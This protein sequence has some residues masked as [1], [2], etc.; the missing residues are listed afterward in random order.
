MPA[1]ALARAPE[2]AFPAKGPLIGLALLQS[3]LFLVPIVVLGQAI[4]WP[5]SLRLPAG[6]VLP[7]IAREAMA[8]QIGYWA[9]L[10]TSL[11]FVPLAVAMRSYANAKGIAGLTVDT[12]AALGVAAGILKTLGIVRW[13]VA[14][15]A[16]ADLY[17]STSDPVQKAAIEVAYSALNG[18][19]GAIGELLGV[20]L[21]SGIWLVLTGII[22]AKIRL[23]WIGTAAMVIGL[24]FTATCARTVMPEA[25]ALQSVAV[26]LALLWFPALAIAI[27][28]R[29]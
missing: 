14:M 9:Y 24:I 17:R 2:P 27:W 1:A 29:G 8:V 25:A 18:Y 10:L 26:P 6:E 19:A 5:G 13:L 22:L 3:G 21:V 7:L 23:R 11:A 16:L 12:A 28:W 15:P 4:G 20:Q